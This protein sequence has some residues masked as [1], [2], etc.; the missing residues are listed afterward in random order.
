MFD[1]LASARLHALPWWV[2]VTGPGRPGN[3]NHRLAAAIRPSI[4]LDAWAY[5]FR[6]MR[7]ARYASRPASQAYRI[8]HAIRSGSRAWAI[9]VFSS[10]PSQPS[11]IA[12]ATSLAV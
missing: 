8:A 6:G 12:T 7:P 1:V 5:S 10:T 2:Y 4:G 11:S 3:G 9:P